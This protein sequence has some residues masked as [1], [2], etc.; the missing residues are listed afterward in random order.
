MG[1]TGRVG[2]AANQSPGPHAITATE[3]GNGTE[4]LNYQYD[5]NGNMTHHATGDLYSWNVDNRLTQVIKGDVV[6]NYQY[7]HSG[8]RVSKRVNRPDSSDDAISLYLSKDFEIREGKIFKFVFA[9]NRRIAKIEEGSTDPDDDPEP[10]ITQTLEFKKGWNFFSFQVQPE[11]NSISNLLD[12][13]STVVERVIT[14]DEEEKRYW[15]YAP[16][17]GIEEFNHLVPGKGYI[18][19]LS[20][21]ATLEV[22]G[23]D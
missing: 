12:S 10:E 22:T 5:D 3:F 1:A 6:S 17:L 14:Y 18:I 8:Q 13:I 21:S 2:R 20:Q 15:R 9:G 11:D 7:D 19:E 23:V 16:D 4:G